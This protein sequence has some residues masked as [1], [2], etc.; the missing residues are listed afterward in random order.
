VIQSRCPPNR[1]LGLAVDGIGVN[2]SLPVF[3]PLLVELDTLRFGWRWVII[4]F[5]LRTLLRPFFEMMLLSSLKGVG[6][7]QLTE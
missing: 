6:E 3:R 7:R 4:H 2:D 5:T 1:N